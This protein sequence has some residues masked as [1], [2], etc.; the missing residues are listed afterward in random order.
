MYARSMQFAPTSS[1]M[2]NM[3]RAGA[4]VRVSV[5]RDITVELVELFR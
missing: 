4:N 5:A 1:W 3:S 2:G